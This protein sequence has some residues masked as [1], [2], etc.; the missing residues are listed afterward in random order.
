VRPHPFPACSYEQ[1]EPYLRAPFIAE[2]VQ[3]RIFA[4]EHPDD[5]CTISLS[6]RSETITGR[7]NTVCG[8]QWSKRTTTLAER[9]IPTA[10]GELHYFRMQS[11]LTLFE[12]T[13]SG[14][15]H[16]SG[17][18]EQWAEANAEAQSLRRAAVL[19]DIGTAF[20]EDLRN[21]IRMPLGD[22]ED[23][24]RSDSEGKPILDARSESYIRRFYERWLDERGIAL[25]GQPFDHRHPYTNLSSR[26]TGRERASRE[27][28][29]QKTM[30]AGEPV[31]VTYSAQ[32]VAALQ[33]LV[34]ETGKPGSPTPT[35]RAWLAVIA[36]M[37]MSEREVI[38]AVDLAAKRSHTRGEAQDRF[39]RWLARRAGRER[40]QHAPAPT[41][42]RAESAT[43]AAHAAPPPDRAGALELLNQQ[44]S[45]NDYG[46]PALRLL[47]GL[48]SGSPPPRRVSL[49]SVS[50]S[51]AARLA[52][53][54]GFAGELGWSAERLA[55]EIAAAQ[56]GSQQRTPAGRFTAFASRLQRLA[57][58]STPNPRR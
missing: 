7:L 42:E 57:E 41:P 52:R 10:A 9:R 33:P 38:L 18:I 43:P 47:L 44:M 24:L 54:L 6:V 16:D 40:H 45:A 11:S 29:P 12:R 1:A 56:D 26:Q 58:I 55:Q 46:E 34:A 15:G 14:T 39:T 51:K 8:S 50:A 5:P 17:L 21:R 27:R 23:Q 28:T 3:A 30:P 22:G 35:V 19:F 4:G 20:Y 49:S 13:M 31:C 25:Y 53:V 36:G 2:A 32:L 37:N 48:A